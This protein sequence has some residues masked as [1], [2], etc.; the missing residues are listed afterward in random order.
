MSDDKNDLDGSELTDHD[1]DG[2]QEY[3]NP[4]PNWWLTV[5]LGTIIFGFLYWLHYFSG[6]APT[7]IEELRSDMVKI[8]AQSKAAEA[9]GA[10]KPDS[11]DDIKKLANDTTVL[12]QGKA[13]FLGKC[14]ACH[15]PQLQGVIGPNLTDE[16]WIH[17]KGTPSDIS[18]VVHAGVLDK[19]MPS[20]GTMLT[21]AEIRSVVVFVVSMQGSNPPNPKAPQG[22]K[23][24]RQ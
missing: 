20:W 11:D 1:Y 16:Y 4:L 2:I 17:G 14:A 23:V 8:E 10:A 18:A 19:G 3:D 21:D 22:E 7:Q 6:A 12:A 15:G 9:S 24:G 13:V 5:F